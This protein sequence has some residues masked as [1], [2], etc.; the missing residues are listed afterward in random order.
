MKTQGKDF[1]YG[2]ALAQIV[3][4]PV[5]TSINKV[6][7]KNGLYQINDDIRILIKYSTA[8]DMEWR[9]TFR[10]DDLEHVF[11]HDIHIVLVCS[12]YTIC[13]L[14]RVDISEIL[15]A[16]IAS[17]QWVSVSCRD[18]EK[19]RVGG[20]LGNLSHPVAHNAFP[21]EVLGSVSKEQE[22]YY[23]WPP[24]SKLKFYNKPPELLYSSEARMLDLSDTLMPSCPDDER[25]VYFG[26]TT[27]SDI[28]DTWSEDNL[29]KIEDHI[30]YD[31]GFDGYDVKIERITDAI[32]GYTG[33]QDKPCYNEFLWKLD[34]CSSEEFEDE[35]MFLGSENS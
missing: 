20:S 4:Y 10:E 1:Y 9:F 24:F 22:S 28:W 2:V 32:C 26:L 23:A 31:L 18:G 35:D 15:D 8:D 11:D 27:V 6:T 5:F 21:K 16:D 7:K 34:I 17:P 29:Q 33:K 19:M 25:T 12:E 13:L 3:E 30:Q 14:S